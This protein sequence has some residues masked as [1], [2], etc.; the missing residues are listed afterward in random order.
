MVVVA[1]TVTWLLSPKMYWYELIDSPLAL[2]APVNVTVSG[3]V[4][5][6]VSDLKL[7]QAI[8]TE[9]VGVGVG[10]EVGGGVGVGV[11]IGVGVGVGVGEL[12]LPMPAN[13]DPPMT[14]VSACK[15]GISA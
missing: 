6:T 2:P 12:Q 13:N 4:P 1:G 8:D 5:E 11:R 15:Y 14:R 3:A 7:V 9:G 10:P